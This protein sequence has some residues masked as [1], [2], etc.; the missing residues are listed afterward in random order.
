MNNLKYEVF[1]VEPNGNYAQLDSEDLEMQTIFAIADQS[2]ITAKKD[3]LG[4]NIKFKA[5]KNNNRVLGNLFNLSRTVNSNSSE[6]LF[7]QTSFNRKV[8]CIVLEDD[9]I[10]LKGYLK[11]L[12]GVKSPNNDISYECLIT[13]NILFFYNKFTDDMMLGDLDFSEFTHKFELQNVIDSWDTKIIKNGSA[14]PFSY[15]NGYVYP[16]INYGNNMSPSPKDSY[17]WEMMN[18]RPAIYLKEYLNKIFTLPLLSGFTFS[19]VGND[20]FIQD[21]DRLIIA[22]DQAQPAIS[23]TANTL[24]LSNNGSITKNPWSSI[25]GVGTLTRNIR[26]GT[27]TDP[28]NLVDENTDEIDGDTNFRFRIVRDFTSNI[29]LTFNLYLNSTGTNNTEAYAR[30]LISDNGSDWSIVAESYITTLSPNSTSNTVAK[31]NI[32]SRA[33]EK[34]KYFKAVLFLK[35]DGAD[36][37]QRTDLII[38]NAKMITPATGTITYNTQ[39][40]DIIRPMPVSNVKIKDFIKSWTQLFNIYTYASIDNPRHIYFESYPDFYRLTSPAL[41][42]SNALDWTKK[43]DYGT[44][45][46]LSG[47]ANTFKKYSFVYKSESDSDYFNTLYYKTYAENQGDLTNVGNTD[48]TND[49]KKIELIFSAT[50]L[51][52]WDGNNRLIPQILTINTDGTRV[53]FKSNIRIMFY[54]GVKNCDP[55]QVG[56]VSRN[57]QG[58]WSISP[59]STPTNSSGT[60]GYYPQSGHIRLD[61]NNIN[62]LVYVRDLNFGK[63]KEYYFT[64]NQNIQTIPDGYTIFYKDQIEEMNDLNLSLFNGD[65][66]LSPTDIS[67]L[68]LKIPVYINTPWG[69]NY[70]KIVNVEYNNRF[71]PSNL[72]LQLIVN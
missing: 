36:L 11:W 72:Q 63:A 71:E 1:I 69:G 17:M 13:G 55:Y 31:L 33:Y 41:L 20:E 51:V 10:I 37:N 44:D 28:I 38:T 39:N 32:P 7:H 27:V 6:Q 58:V 65:F 52:K 24:T 67:N 56:N 35:G 60:F 19:I 61:D 42:H 49:E 46:T 9:V 47:N 45:I 23:T 54:N 62:E 70:Y 5:T 53:P 48:A 59:Y 21:Q 2:D 30:L 57:D 16:M 64:A 4:K 12:Q 26:F 25:G 68:D 40:G 50:P 14:I 3:N 43:L 66:L 29:L 34:G 15:G 18:Y 8:E 22:N